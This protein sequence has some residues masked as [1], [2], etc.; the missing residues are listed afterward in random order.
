MK[1]DIFDRQRET[2]RDLLFG[3]AP[4][5][6]A[7]PWPTV[8]TPT[9]LMERDTAVELGGYPKESVNLIL[10][11]SNGGFRGESGVY[12]LGSP[13][14]LTAGSTHI[15]YGKVVFLQTGELAEE[16]IYDYLQS[17]Q[18]TDIRLRLRHIMR[19]TSSE[20]F[21]V[22]L[23]VGKR[24]IAEGFRLEQMGAAILDHFL[25]LPEVRAAE[26][27]LILGESPVY[28]ELLPLA[29]KVKEMTVALNTMFDGIDMDCGH[30]N[31]QPVCAEVEG[32]RIL[33]KASVGK[34]K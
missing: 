22:N 14:A 24:A 5:S 31:L 8:S 7:E 2:A 4:L 16:K 21:H 33:H 6:N 26:V 12:L 23:R 19:R 25:A 15:A 27:V 20:Q 32:L 10:S 17:V 28:R 34:Y 18:I 13:D 1:L 29:G 11:S 30:C 9:F 3:A